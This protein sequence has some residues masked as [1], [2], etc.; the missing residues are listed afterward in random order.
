MRQRKY[1]ILSLDVAAGSTGWSFSVKT[2]LVDYGV[3]KTS[4][5][6]KRAK[7]LMKFREQLE[8]ILRKY[9]PSHI[10]IENGYL[11][12]NV[13]TLK[14]LSEFAGVAKALCMGVLGI[15]PYI[16][17]VNTTRSFFDAKGKEEIFNKVIG[18]YDLKFD[19][20]KDND[21]TDA[22]SQSLCF[23]YKVIKGC[24]KFEDTKKRSRV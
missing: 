4:P 13:N 18:F 21:I 15:E 12:R 6:L 5:S 16:M 3:I 7:R 11:R 17:N 8:K 23:Y 14:I 10:V 1:G 20:K 2:R 9:K 22:V 19:F 24:E